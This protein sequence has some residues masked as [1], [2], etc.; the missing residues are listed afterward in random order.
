MEPKKK[1]Q[2]TKQN[3]QKSNYKMRKKKIVINFKKK[4][5]IRMKT[6][7]QDTYKIIK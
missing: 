2:V 6:I 7:Q 4:Y 1:K 3:I 5:Y